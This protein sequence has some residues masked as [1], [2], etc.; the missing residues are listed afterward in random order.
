MWISNIKSRIKLRTLI[1]FSIC[2][3][4]VLLPIASCVIYSNS[5]LILAKIISNKTLTPVTITHID[6][7]RNSFTIRDLAISNPKDAYIPTAFKAETV[8][9]DASYNQYFKSAI[10][11]DKI[12]IND[13]YLNIEFYTEDKMKGNWQG[14]IENMK[15]SHQDSKKGKRQA[16]IKKLILNNVQ[17]NLILSD[18]KM[19]RLSPIDRIEF[20]DVTSEEGIQIEEISEMIARKMV[21]SILKEE[22]LNLI[23]EIPLKVIKKI[24]P[25][26]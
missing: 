1:I 10:V 9:V 7:H 19:H 14:L 5:D 23:I 15:A 24:L 16:I 26:L 3:C 12:E 25:F 2:A 22:R 13:I 21:Y 4:V 18:G 17:V 20:Q 6:F 11:I 8:V